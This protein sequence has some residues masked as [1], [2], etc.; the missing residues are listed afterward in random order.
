[1]AV[2]STSLVARAGAADAVAVEVDL[3][4]AGRATEVVDVDSICTTVVGVV[5]AVDVDV[6]FTV[7]ADAAPAVDDGGFSARVAD[8]G[9]PAARGVVAADL[10]IPGLLTKQYMEPKVMGIPLYRSA[11]TERWAGGWKAYLK[12]PKRMGSRVVQTSIFIA[13]G[14]GA[15][16]FPTLVRSHR[17]RQL[18][19]V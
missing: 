1:M 3:G 6:I 16:M 19:R 7:V 15:T 2:A 8:A 18:T 9:A 11:Y 4:F 5:H 13:D 14:A 10:N 17:R 12:E